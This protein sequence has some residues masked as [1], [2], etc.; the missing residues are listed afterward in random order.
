[1]TAPVLQ[2]C[3]GHGTTG[4]GIMQDIETKGLFRLRYRIMVNDGPK[5][6]VLR[7]A[8][9]ENSDGVKPVAGVTILDE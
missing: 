8:K 1:M 6:I 3:F 5:P 4:E 7:N 9:A 2:K